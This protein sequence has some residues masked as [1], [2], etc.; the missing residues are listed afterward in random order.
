[1]SVKVTVE[2]PEHLAQRARAA[3]ASSHRQFEDVIVEWISRAVGDPDV[4]HLS[5]AEVLALCDGEMA[6]DQQQ[7][8]SELLAR[9][10]EN[11]VGQ[12]DGARLDELMATYRRGL[13]RKAQAWK[14][15]V[16]RGLKHSI[17]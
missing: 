17:Q 1:M 10:R 16:A 12:A 15:A 11:A 4:E 9:Q 6:D 3:A 13:V 2:L 8:L 7:E 14:V 5:D